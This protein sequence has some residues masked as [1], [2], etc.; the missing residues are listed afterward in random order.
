MGLFE[1]R[2]KMHNSISLSE[3][4]LLF[5]RNSLVKSKFVSYDKC[6]MRRIL[7][8]FLL[9]I[10]SAI[11][12][13]QVV[14]GPPGGG[15]GGT[16]GGGGPGGGGVTPPGGGSWVFSTEPEGTDTISRPEYDNTIPGYRTV[17]YVYNWKTHIWT[18]D[19]V[20]MPP[21]M[22]PGIGGWSSGG[23]TWTASMSSSGS[24]KMKLK[25]TGSLVGLPDAIWVKVSSIAQSLQFYGTQTADNGLGD[26]SI[27]DG[28]STISSGSRL[29]RLTVNALGEV[30]TTIS[31]SA[32]I[33]QTGTS[34]WIIAGCG[35]S[36][37]KDPRSIF[38]PNNFMVVD[39]PETTNYPYKVWKVPGKVTHYG[40][41]PDPTQYSLSLPYA[42]AERVKTP[43]NYSDSVTLSANYFRGLT[44]SVEYHIATANLLSGWTF[45]DGGTK[46]TETFFHAD[47]GGESSGASVSWSATHNTTSGNGTLT[48]ANNGTPSIPS[49]FQTDGI[50]YDKTTDGV[51]HVDIIRT[52]FSR[53]PSGTFTANFTFLSDGMKANANVNFEYKS[54]ETIKLTGEKKEGIFGDSTPTAKNYSQGYHN[55]DNIVFSENKDLSDAVMLASIVVSVAASAEGIP[56]PIIFSMVSAGLGGWLDSSLNDPESIT[57]DRF[58]PQVETAGTG[59][60]WKIEDEDW[61]DPELPETKLEY[62]NRCAYWSMDIFVYYDIYPSVVD[63]YNDSGFESRGTGV[64]LDKQDG[65]PKLP[66]GVRYYHYKNSSTGGGATAP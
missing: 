5:F 20:A 65:L 30:E 44:P 53:K 24:V 48:G 49:T 11:S 21:G 42:V 36:M 56:M 10:L 2:F 28:E 41:E 63:R 62:A 22:A 7:T 50:V 18:R 52:P 12:F 54:Q 3:I 19:G 61:Y 47:Y 39:K 34:G 45:V 46:N 38:I 23:T 1:Y 29:R 51:G 15:G 16:T 17:T 9:V 4:I 6:V 27:F 26:P 43:I 60:C 35:C 25:W 31:L 66:G 32:S 37:A 14:G 58:R 57:L 55:S 40:V 13:S 33:S 8:I 64:K 59:I